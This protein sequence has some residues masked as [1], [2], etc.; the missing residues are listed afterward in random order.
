V[1]AVVLAGLRCLI[2]HV[3]WGIP[4]GTRQRPSGA[5]LQPASS[6]GC[7]GGVAPD[8]G[9]PTP[10]IV[11]PESADS[12]QNAHFRPSTVNHTQRYTRR[13]E[14]CWGGSAQVNNTATIM[15]GMIRGIP[16]PSDAAMTQ[17]C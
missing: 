7:G 5:P 16:G 11:R 4:I 3:C 17:E 1:T 10:S 6:A 13:S 8:C 15:S 9:P 14:A 12:P 2:W